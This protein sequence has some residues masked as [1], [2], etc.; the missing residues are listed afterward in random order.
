[1]KR[2]IAIILTL[3]I[4]SCG[5]IGIG[6]N[7][8]TTIF[9]NS[10]DVISASSDNGIFKIKPNE[11]MRVRAGNGITIKTP[12]D[13]CP[14]PIIARRPNSAAIFLDIFPGIIFGIVP[15]AADAI[16]N[17][18]YKMPRQYTYACAE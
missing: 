16:T 14:Q 2:L 8:E 5:T 9:N 1:M 6:S 18:L 13:N 10:S 4:T 17:N 12:N 11:K 7:H 3:G 15:L